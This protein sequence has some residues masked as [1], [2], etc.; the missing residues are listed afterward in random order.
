MNEFSNKPTDDTANNRNEAYFQ[1]TG[2]RLTDETDKSVSP[3]FE[4]AN[5]ILKI[6]DQEEIVKHGHLL[7]EYRDIR[8]ILPKRTQFH[9]DEFVQYQIAA[10]HYELLIGELDAASLRLQ[11]LTELGKT[12]KLIQS[13]A[14]EI[15]LAYIE[16]FQKNL[17]EEQITTKQVQSFPKV[18]YSPKNEAPKLQHT[19]LQLFYATSIENVDFDELQALYI[20]YG[21]F[22]IPDLEAILLDSMH[23]YESFKNADV[24]S[25]NRSFVL[26]ALYFLGALQAEDSLSKV[27]DFLR[28][29]E[30]FTQFWLGSDVDYLL[31]TP[32]YSLG[33]NQL[34]ALK[35]FALEENIYVWNKV[36]VSDVVSQVAHHHPERRQEVI[37][38][39]KEVFAHFLKSTKNENLIDTVF[40]TSAATAAT[41]LR[42]VVLLPLI[43]ALY[44]R[45]W[46]D[47]NIYG[48]I[49]KY[50]ADI[51]KPIPASTLEPM[52]E[53]LQEYYTEE[54]RNRKAEPEMELAEM[55]KS[56]SLLESSE[57]KAFMDMFTKE[58]EAGNSEIEETLLKK[59]KR[60]PPTL[61]G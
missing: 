46:I 26:H 57:V 27:L 8:T 36:L 53:N 29:G 21:T 3:V 59:I 23:R 2:I 20:K 33:K 52:P 6:H 35:V 48:N 49:K 37:N 40:I 39:Y 41:K 14:H 56:H 31:F 7:G 24:S 19:E 17:E 47:P 54:Y 11:S 15:S 60:L 1:K 45:K 10:A 38:W 16:N 32:L 44:E 4:I 43:E 42:A 51:Q 61:E 9:I 34:S 30:E 28:M 50:K 58:G 55:V 12:N 22:L 18:T 5:Q 13:L 25:E